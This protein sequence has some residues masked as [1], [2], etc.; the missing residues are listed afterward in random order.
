MS[1]ASYFPQPTSDKFVYN[2]ENVPSAV[3]PPHEAFVQ[4]FEKRYLASVRQQGHWLRTHNSGFISEHLET[5][6]QEG[7]QTQ[8]LAY[9]SCP[10]TDWPL[11]SGELAMIQIRRQV[12]KDG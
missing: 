2:L 12:N 9:H 3:F 6:Q 11:T 7:G 1:A 4:Q 10:C 5:Q 8:Q